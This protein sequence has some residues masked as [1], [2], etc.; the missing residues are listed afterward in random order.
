MTRPPSP[1][2]KYL[3]FL[4]LLP[5]WPWLFGCHPTVSLNLSQDDPAIIQW[6]AKISDRVNQ[7]EDRLHLLETEVHHG[8]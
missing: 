7:L 3:P 4:L 1:W 2:L 5:F 6:R 8:Q